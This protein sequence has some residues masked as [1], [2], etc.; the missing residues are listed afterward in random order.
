MSMKKK[1]L[2]V[3]RS[4]DGAVLPIILMTFMVLMILISSV[5]ILFSNNLRQTKRQEEMVKAHYIALSGIELAMA[6][7][8]QEGII[9]GAEDTLLY[10]QFGSHIPLA[11]TPELEDTLTLD[12]GEVLIKI[13]AI[14]TG[15]RWVEIR[16]KGTLVNMD[17]TRIIRLRFLVHNPEVQR[18]DPN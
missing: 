8:L 17:A 6:A 10:S 15:E 13:R 14:D 16:S 11:N 18:W 3:L 7:L 9:G 4:R 2:N 12:N 5:I 1:A